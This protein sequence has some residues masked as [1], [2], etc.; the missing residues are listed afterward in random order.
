MNKLLIVD[1]SRAVHAFVKEALAY[2][3]REFADAFDGRQALDILKAAG[4]DVELVLL[5]WEMPV[6]TGI[7]TVA[8]IRA[9]GFRLPVI[10]VTSLS[11]MTNIARALDA[12]AD[13]YVMKP[14]TKEI[15]LEKISEVLARRAA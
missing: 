7:E 11:D 13:D 5:D 6:M 8:A 14:F 10:M 2:V 9:A 4:S 1:D 12:G 3:G 15:L